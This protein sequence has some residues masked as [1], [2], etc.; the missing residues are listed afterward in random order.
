MFSLKE[1]L[2]S[3]FHL[4][5]QGKNNQEEEVSLQQIEEARSHLLSL[6]ACLGHALAQP[7]GYYANV[8][9]Y[10]C[11][12]LEQICLENSLGANPQNNQHVGLSHLRMGSHHSERDEEFTIW[13]GPVE[14]IFNFNGK[15]SRLTMTNREDPQQALT[16]TDPEEI[17]AVAQRLDSFSETT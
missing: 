14:F 17:L 15:E 2:S 4:P 13:T 1:T 6:D 8:P 10:V 12:T 3:H 9:D 7:Q 11:Q 16:M 5:R